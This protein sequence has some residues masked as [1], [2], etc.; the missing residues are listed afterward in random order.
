MKS[1]QLQS[2]AEH[3]V[4]GTGKV[5]LGHLRPRPCPGVGEGE[6]DPLPA[7]AQIRIGEGGVAQAEAEGEGH[8]FPNGLVIAVAHKQPLPVLRR[9]LPPGEVPGV[10]GVGQ[11]QG[12]SLCQTAGGV[13]LPGEQVGGG[14]RPR[15][16][17]QVPVKQG[18]APVQ[19][20]ELQRAAPRQ[21]HCHVGVGLGHRLQGADLVVRQGQVVPVQPLALKAL[22]DA[23]KEDDRLRL[24]GQ[25]RRLPLQALRGLA[26]PAVGLG[27]ADDG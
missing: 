9:P 8:G 19:P 1:F 20:G 24:T 25:L 18:L 15:L 16:P 2:G 11:D 5:H 17:P 27:V 23:Q 14:P 12:K 4:P 13:H 6:G 3:P 21:H 26:V 7:D 10:G 22:G